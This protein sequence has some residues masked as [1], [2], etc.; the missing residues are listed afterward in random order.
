MVE[1]Q[2]FAFD[3]LLHDGRHGCIIRYNQMYHPLW[4]GMPLATVNT[5]RLG[6][7]SMIVGLFQQHMN[8]NLA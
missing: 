6:Q 3:G 8:I 7:L 5:S 4:P 1:M 2:T